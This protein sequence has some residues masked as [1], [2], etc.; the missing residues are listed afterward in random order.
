LNHTANKVLSR[1]Q[2]SLAYEFKDPS[3]LRLA[4]THRSAD[5]THNQRLE[6][7]GD[8]ALGFV[9]AERLYQINADAPEGLLSQFRAS[10]VNRETLAALARGVHLGDYLNLG[11]GELKSGG[12]ERDSILCD[13]LEAIFGAVYLDGGMKACAHCILHLLSERLDGLG[14]DEKHKDAKTSLQELMQSRNLA[15][16]RYTVIG[17]SGEEHEQMFTV[18]CT[19]SLLEN[20]TRGIGR[21]RRIAEQEAA[22]LAL[23]QLDQTTRKQ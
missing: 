21:S 3:L 7:L 13:A 8:A 4:L 11:Q 17:V 9:V 20:A 1:L 19:I 15:L 5:K 6:F 22:Q 18:D 14:F 12:R 23:D 16:P 10:L 2:S